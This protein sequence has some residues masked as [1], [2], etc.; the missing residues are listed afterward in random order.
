MRLHVLQ[1]LWSTLASL[2]VT[3]WSFVYTE[4]VFT[5]VLH[6]YLNQQQISFTLLKAL[7]KRTEA[8]S[9]LIEASVAIH[10]H[11]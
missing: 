11:Q 7:H 1:G 2:H 10:G 3:L 9:K 6:R 5:I 4:R 8:L